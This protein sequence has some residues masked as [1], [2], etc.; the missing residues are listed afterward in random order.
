MHIRK[1]MTVIKSL[2]VMESDITGGT[3]ELKKQWRMYILT[4]L[5]DGPK[6]LGRVILYTHMYISEAK[7]L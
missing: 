4:L 2:F 1:Q 6:G 3:H 7:R 5:Y